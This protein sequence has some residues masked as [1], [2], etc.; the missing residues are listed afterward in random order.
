[1]CTVKNKFNL[2]DFVQIVLGS[3][4]LTVPLAVTEEVFLLSQKIPI[5]KVVC[6]SF[7][8]LL[9][10][11]LYIYYGV[12][13]AK[14]KNKALFLKRNIINIFITI[15]TVVFVVYLLDINSKF[16][17]VKN[18]LAFVAILTFPAFFGGV[19]VDGFDKE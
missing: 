18:L 6:I 1:M 14:V 5:F 16:E 13:E 11:S 7:T 15:S 10:N 19:V 4:L 17:S 12:F 2:E 9:V 3:T 8:A